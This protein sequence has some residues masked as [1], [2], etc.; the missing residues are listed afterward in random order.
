MNDPREARVIEGDATVVEDAAHAL[1]DLLVNLQIARPGDLVTIDPVADAMAIEIDS[2]EMAVICNEEMQKNKR[3][4]NA[5]EAKRKDSVAPIDAARSKVQDFFRP[6]LEAFDAADGIYKGKLLAWKKKEDARI[7]EEQRK[8]REAA[9]AERRRQAEAEA[10]A[11]A[12]AEKESAE[13]RERAAAAAAEGNA[14]QAAK[15]EARAE[16]KVIQGEAKAQEIAVQRAATAAVVAPPPVAAKLKGTG[17]RDNWKAI[18]PPEKKGEILAFIAANPQYHHLVEF[19]QS[20]L[21]QMA[22][23]LKD[24]LPTTIPGLLVTNDQ[25]ITTR[26]R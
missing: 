22:K 15:L 17:V 23:A 13:L 7:A 20:A 25:T 21:N 6:F 5:V 14:V 3:L 10:A 4:S 18:A 24:M 1:P 19:N 9:E 2:P 16:E 11:R 26:T 12:Q 8:A